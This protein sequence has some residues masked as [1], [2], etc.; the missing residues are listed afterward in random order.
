M[1]MAFSHS[2]VGTVGRKVA[3]AGVSGNLPLER[4]AKA[5]GSLSQAGA[6]W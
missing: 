4:G 3:G 1:S 2:A 5:I 6:G